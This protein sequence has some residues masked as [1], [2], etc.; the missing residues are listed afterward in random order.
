MLSPE[1]HLIRSLQEELG[2]FDQAVDQTTV[3]RQTI[4]TKLSGLL[5]HIDNLPIDDDKRVS[6]VLAITNT[7][8]KALDAQEASAVRRV[9]TKIKQQDQRRADNTAIQVTELLQ[10]MSTGSG[11]TA[12]MPEINLDAESAALLEKFALEGH[13]I[14]ETELRADPEDLS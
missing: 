5:H 3:A 14:L 1:D 2:H 9:N 13:A 7:T 11:S 10:R 6:S 4:V 8:L 12:E